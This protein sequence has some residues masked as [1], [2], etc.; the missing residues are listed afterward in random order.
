MKHGNPECTAW[1]GRPGFLQGR[2]GDLDLAV[3]IINRGKRWLVISVT[4]PA[5][6]VKPTLE[7]ALDSLHFLDFRP[8]NYPS[9]RR[10]SSPGASRAAKDLGR[11]KVVRI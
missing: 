10:H 4:L 5:G 11:R 8:L 1:Q 7:Q 3:G 2:A 9:N 6:S